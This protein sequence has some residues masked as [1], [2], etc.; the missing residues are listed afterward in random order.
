[1][2]RR[3]FLHTTKL[4][5]AAAATTALAPAAVA[6]ERHPEGAPVMRRFDEQRWVLDNIIQANSIDWDQGHTNGLIRACGTAVIGD[7]A[8]LKRQVRKYADIAP[9]F[10]AMARRRETKAKEAEHEGDA[11][12][13][14]D[15]YFIAAQYWAS[16]MWPID[17]VN[18]RIK[19]YNDKKRETFGKYMQLA[20]HKV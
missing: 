10:E 14:R 16:A 9:A 19:R 13:A 8:N 17:E 1:M 4:A 15:N 7:M 12:E 11:I 2:D 18:D 6:A 5:A 20:D 3:E